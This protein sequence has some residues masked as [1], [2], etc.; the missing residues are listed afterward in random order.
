MTELHIAPN[1]PVTV[2]LSDPEGQF[3]FDRGMGRYQTTAGETLTLPRAAVVLLNTLDPK[4]GEEITITKI[5]SGRP[6]DKVRWTIALSLRAEKARTAAGEPDTLTEQLE[7][8]IEQAKTRKA[9][10]PPPTPITRPSKRKPAAESQPR[11]FDRGTGTDGP[12]PRPGPSSLPATVHRPAVIPWNVAFREVSAW[13][14]KELAANNLQWG[15]EAQKSM[16]CTVLIAE[17][18]AGRIGPWERHG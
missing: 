7:A 1:K 5:W 6:A 8:S 12:A 14:S 18:K 9:N 3:D 11:L 4:P 15:D 10:Q 2:A 13:V 17:A 16:C